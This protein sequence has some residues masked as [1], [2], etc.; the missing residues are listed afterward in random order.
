M[1]LF[2]NRKTEKK[3]PVWEEDKEEK[4]QFRNESS[5]LE[6]RHTDFDALFLRRVGWLLFL[7]LE[8]LYLFLHRW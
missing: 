8:L 2:P 1:H 5:L 7:S 4:G 3:S 6:R